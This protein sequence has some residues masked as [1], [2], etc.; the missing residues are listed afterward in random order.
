[1]AREQDY[2]TIGS[3]AVPLLSDFRLAGECR[4]LVNPK[5][6]GLLLRAPRRSSAQSGDG[7]SYRV[8][9]DVER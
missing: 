5:W 2:C 8:L 1:M 6:P 7:E 3:Y 9:D 4:L